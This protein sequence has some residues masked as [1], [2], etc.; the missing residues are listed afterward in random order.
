M[1]TPAIDVVDYGGWAGVP[2]LAK[3]LTDAAPALQAWK[4]AMPRL[5][6][7]RRNENEEIQKL[8]HIQLLR[9]LIAESGAASS[10][11][12]AATWEEIAATASRTGDDGETILV[13]VRKPAMDLVATQ[14]ATADLTPAFGAERPLR[15]QFEVL[16]MAQVKRPRLRPPKTNGSSSI[17]SAPPALKPE[18]GHAVAEGL[19]SQV[20]AARAE[21]EPHSAGDGPD[22]V[23]PVQ[24]E[25][26]MTLRSKYLHCVETCSDGMYTACRW[27]K[28]VASRKPIP[29][30]R[31]LWRGDREEALT[32]AMD[33]C[34]DRAYLGQDCGHP[35]HRRA[36][37][38]FR[39]L[40]GGA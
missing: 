26:V 35:R 12:P 10:Q 32:M 24:R 23:K 40:R 2:E 14:C 29:E 22:S 37:A 19:P 11:A 4:R 3:V 16:P 21:A 33:F 8:L 36:P 7:D 30:D 18:R 27:R 39:S 17:F 6:D 28:G 15:R 31:V 9:D 25:W 1:D 34:P 20:V 13:R 38:G 5:Y